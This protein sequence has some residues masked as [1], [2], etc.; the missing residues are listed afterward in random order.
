LQIERTPRFD[1]DVLVAGADDRLF[2]WQLVRL[3]T[4]QL[5]NLNYWAT[6]P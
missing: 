3:A 6:T 2:Q 1:D 5:G 4:Q